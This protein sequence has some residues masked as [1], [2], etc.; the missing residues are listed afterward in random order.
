MSQLDLDSL[1]DIGVIAAGGRLAIL[2]AT[3]SAGDEYAPDPETIGQTEA[4]EVNE[5]IAPEAERRQITL[6]GLGSSGIWFRKGTVIQAQ[7]EQR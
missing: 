4:D 7:S 5:R 3:C 6:T 1:K 2:R